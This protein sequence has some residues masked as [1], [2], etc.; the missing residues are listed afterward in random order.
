LRR[1]KRRKD[2]PSIKGSKKRSRSIP[3]EN[4][5]KEIRDT[6][7]MNKGPIEFQSGF[8]PLDLPRLARP[9]SAP[10]VISIFHAFGRKKGR[11]IWY[12][13]YLIIV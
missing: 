8:A 6:A 11:Q 7:S 5:R 10:F 4:E 3:N 2:R 13:P 12:N 9:I 1:T